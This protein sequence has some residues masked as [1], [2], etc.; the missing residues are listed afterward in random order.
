MHSAPP[1]VQ[2]P[3]EKLRPHLEAQT[4]LD[5]PAIFYLHLEA[6]VEVELNSR[7]QSPARYHY[8]NPLQIEFITSSMKAKYIGLTGK[9]QLLAI[10]IL[11]FWTGYA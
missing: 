5:V 2:C 6:H 7:H 4:H 9:Q 11:H 3:S 10:Y 1:T 8:A